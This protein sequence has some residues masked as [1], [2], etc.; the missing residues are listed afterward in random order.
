MRKSS[1]IFVISKI[2]INT[3]WRIS[4]SR[5]KKIMA[6]DDLDNERLIY[7]MICKFLNFIIIL[8]L[9]SIFFMS[10]PGWTAQPYELKQHIYYKIEKNGHLAG[11]AEEYLEPI[12]TLPNLVVKM[13]MK[14]AVGVHFPLL[15][16]PQYIQEEIYEIDLTFDKLIRGE[17]LFHNLLNNQQDTTQIDFNHFKF[18]QVI[19]Q[20]KDKPEKLIARNAIPGFHRFSGLY[21]EQRIADKTRQGNFLLLWAPMGESINAKWQILSDTTL[22][23]NGHRLMCHHFLILNQKNRPLREIWTLKNSARL[24]QAYD[25][26]TQLT[27]VL[28]DERYKNYFEKPF[29]LSTLKPFLTELNLEFFTVNPDSNWQTVSKIHN[30]SLA[31]TGFPLRIIFPDSVEKYLTPLTGNFKYDTD[32]LFRFGVTLTKDKHYLDEALLVFTRWCGKEMNVTPL[33]DKKITDWVASDWQQYLETL[34]IFTQLCR[35][36]NLPAR[37][38][39]GFYCFSIIKLTCYKWC[40]I[41]IFDG[42][43]WIPWHL[44]TPQMP[45]GGAE[46]IK[47]KIVTGEELQAFKPGKFEQVKLKSYQFETQK[48][49]ID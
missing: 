19:D 39:E 21:L 34:A 12:Q 13:W 48:I 29:N 17:I 11:Y 2:T 23:V 4:C 22:S 6:R 47:S 7:Q 42:K 28:V 9:S 24:V 44:E 43:A 3:V 36:N 40:W 10:N 38:V 35:A 14:T 49:L 25:F 26:D 30:A 31:E 45:F 5:C 18:K 37:F 15:N 41:E 8:M 1:E 32:E 27:S 20:K 33:F 16:Q 46:F